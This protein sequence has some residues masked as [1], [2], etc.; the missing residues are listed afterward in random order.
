MRTVVCVKPAPDPRYWQKM[1]LDPETGT[2]RREEV[3]AVFG[4][5]DRR[6]LEE[7]LRIK[8]LRG[9]RVTMLSMAPPWALKTLYKGLAMG[10][11]EAV[12]LSDPSFAGADTVATSYVLA[13]GIT[14][15]AEYDLV[16]CGD[17]SLDVATG[18]VGPQVAEFL[19]IPHVTHVCK[20]DLLDG[21]KVRVEARTDDGYIVLEVSLPAVLGV[22]R[23]INE[24]RLVSLSGI[25]EAG[26]KE[27]K[28]WA[29]GDLG[30]EKDKVGLTGSPT[31]VVEMFASERQRDGELL[32]GQ[33]EE[34]V[35]L[36]IRRLEKL[37]ALL[38]P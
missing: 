14:K 15:L 37:G 28:L 1:R 38:P 5:L 36:L 16:L 11:D 8:E 31:Q 6:A 26:E 33:P 21:D 19:G 30:V 13:A 29:A 24:P 23:E 22:E 34:I 7:A 25:S 3:P 9:G 27:I 12:L 18:Q 17:K 2:L 32:K 4:P 35:E 20:L 10:A